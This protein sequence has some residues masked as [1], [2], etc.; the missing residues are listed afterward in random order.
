M[1]EYKEIG[2]ICPEVLHIHDQYLEHRY[3]WT[4]CRDFVKGEA[5][6]KRKNELYLPI[7]SGFILSEKTALASVDPSY[8][9]GFSFDKKYNSIPDNYLDN[10]NYH[11]NRPY[12]IY[13]HGAKVPSILKHTINGL[14]GLIVKKPM[15]FI[16]EESDIYDL[17]TLDEKVENNLDNNSDELN[18]EE[19]GNTEND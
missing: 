14:L 19:K 6:V 9:Q 5:A 18:P 2:E 16:T 12:S 4:L 3:M 13:K 1:I 11:P 10:P 15:E 7:P 17:G 8:N